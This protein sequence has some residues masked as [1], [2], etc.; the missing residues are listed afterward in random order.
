VAQPV[1]LPRFRQ[2]RPRLTF[3]AIE[4]P[5]ESPS[6]PIAIEAPEPMT[7]TR[8]RRAATSERARVV[9]ESAGHTR[10]RRVNQ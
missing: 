4:P 6:M 2:R 7:S 3:S 9:G 8:A 5:L 1:A 10:R